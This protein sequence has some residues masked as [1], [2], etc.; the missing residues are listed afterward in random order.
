MFR[1][2]TEFFG[3]YTHNN[4]Y[5]ETSNGRMVFTKKAENALISKVIRFDKQ[6]GVWVAA[7]ENKDTI[8]KPFWYSESK[9]QF[10]AK[11]GMANHQ[12]W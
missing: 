3:L 2:V 11:I 9:E 6:K 10:L 12:K 4:N 5:D 1:N 7:N 8:P